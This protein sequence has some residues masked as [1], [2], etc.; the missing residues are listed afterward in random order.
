MSHVA[1]RIAFQLYDLGLRVLDDF[2]VD[3][4]KV[5]VLSGKNGRVRDVVIIKDGVAM[6]AFAKPSWFDNWATFAREV[7][8]GIVDEDVHVEGIV[9]MVGKYFM[10]R[11]Y[12]SNMKEDSPEN[13][14]KLINSIHNVQTA[15]AKA[16][17][18]K[19]AL[20]GEHIAKEMLALPAA[21]LEDAPLHKLKT[22]WFDCRDRILEHFTADPFLCKMVGRSFDYDMIKPLL[23]DRQLDLVGTMVAHTRAALMLSNAAIFCFCASMAY[24][25]E[26]S[27]IDRV[28]AVP[29]EVDDK[30][31]DQHGLL[32]MF[33]PDMPFEPKAELVRVLTERGE[34][35]ARLGQIN[36]QAKRIATMGLSRQVP[37][38]TSAM[39]K[40][41]EI[42]Y[43]EWWNDKVGRLETYADAMERVCAERGM[44]SVE[45]FNRG[46]SVVPVCQEFFAPAP[47]FNHPDDFEMVMSV[48]TGAVKAE[49]IIR[50]LARL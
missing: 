14:L 4:M 50:A 46:I 26:L 39:M 8:S 34:P 10:E 29:I 40:L 11:E 33:F 6:D 24:T 23:E 49:D 48:A 9:F 18:K 5:Y 3:D 1:D 36:V 2:Q 35:R 28:Y 37:A 43:E 20:A 32:Y 44:T 25:E 30:L 42:G 45:L 13:R 7:D 38:V 41:R 27:D 19:P 21:P 16:T 15:L 47:T 17:Q 31:K 12:V 22:Y